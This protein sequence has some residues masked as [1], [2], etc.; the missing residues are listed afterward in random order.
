M[1]SHC[2]TLSIQPI[3]QQHNLLQC[4]MVYHCN[5][6]FRQDC[7]RKEAHHHQHHEAL[8]DVLS[9]VPIRTLC[10]RLCKGSTLTTRNQPL[11]WELCKVQSCLSHP[12]KLSRHAKL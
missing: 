12:H 2:R 3:D 11:L 1:E 9:S 6:K 10:C 8:S 7:R 4:R 5:P